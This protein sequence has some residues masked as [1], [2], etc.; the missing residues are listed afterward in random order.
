MSLTNRL[1]S[2]KR[3]RVD[4]LPVAPYFSCQVDGLDRRHEVA[5]HADGTASA[6][7][8]HL[9]THEPVLPDDELPAIDESDQHLRAG[10]T[11]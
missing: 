7:E 11:R 1:R 10:N 6:S 9:R 5:W 2:D 4:S 8:P 3:R